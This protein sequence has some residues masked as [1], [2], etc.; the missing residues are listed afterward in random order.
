MENQ[1]INIEINDE[2][3]QGIFA[4]LALINHSP[5]EFI[6]D[7]LQ[8]MP[9]L[10][11]ARVKSRIILTP[12]HAKRLVAALA[13]NVQK[14]EASFGEIKDPEPMNMMPMNFGSAAGEA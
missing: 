14:Y 7:F 1:E 12:A 10:P 8:M 5:T 4:N 11:K 9:G 13:D 3:A 6:V 2:V